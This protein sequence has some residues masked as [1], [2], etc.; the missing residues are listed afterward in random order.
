MLLTISQWNSHVNNGVLHSFSQ[1]QCLGSFLFWFFVFPTKEHLS[2]HFLPSTPTLFLFLLTFYTT[3]QLLLG[4]WGCIL[5]NSSPCCFT[6]VLYEEKTE[7]QNRRGEDWGRKSTWPFSV[8]F[9]L[10][11]YFYSCL[12]SRYSSHDSPLPSQ[13]FPLLC[14]PLFQLSLSLCDWEAKAALITDFI[15][16]DW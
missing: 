1:K 6:S 15:S 11:I 3:S 2:S 7:L 4:T 9:K 5:M 10:F 12:W 13:I 16:D 8:Y 14:H